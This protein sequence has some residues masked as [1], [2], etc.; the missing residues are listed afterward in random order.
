MFTISPENQQ[1]LVEIL[2]DATAKVIRHLPGFVSAN[3]HKSVDGTRVANY[4][5]WK[6]KE[7]FDA[8][9]KNPDVQP[10]MRAALEVSPHLYEVSYIESTD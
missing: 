8:M 10:H 9:L 1:R 3:I 4:A 7:D 6:T 5:Q 2:A